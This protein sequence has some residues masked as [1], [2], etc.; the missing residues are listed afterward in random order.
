[1]T[2]VNFVHPAGDVLVRQIEARVEDGVV[3]IT[4]LVS[5]DIWDHIEIEDVFGA[6]TRVRHGSLAAGGE[7]RITVSG[8][9][10]ATGPGS[11]PFARDW[12]IDSATRRVEGAEGEVWI[13]V[14][15]DMAP[16]WLG[17]AAGLDELGLTRTDESDVSVTYR[18]DDGTS[19]EVVADVQR[20]LATVT[21]RRT[22]GLPDERSL[23][24]TLKVLNAINDRFVAGTALLAGADLVLKT[25]LPI[26]ENGDV[27][28]VLEDLAY[29]LPGMTGMVF[30]ATSPVV[31][32]KKSAADA[33]Q[34]L[35]G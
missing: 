25:G 18:D 34:E 32:G 17:A 24:E 1:M 5:A 8:A 9:E 2:D 35:F 33:I 19:V 21:C 16:Q 7:V 30:E 14:A 13:G 28:A 10:S 29:A 15:F 4:G 22:V 11:G 3:S 23:T 27:S 26:P 6:R 12:Q 20:R 31:A